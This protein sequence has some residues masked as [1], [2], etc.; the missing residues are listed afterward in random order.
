MNLY[1][2]NKIILI[3]KINKNR[4]IFVIKLIQ[5]LFQFY[6]LYIISNYYSFKKRINKKNELIKNSINEIVK[7]KDK[8]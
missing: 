2:F 8:Q 7:L 3:S 6:Y 1:L 5:I 4:I